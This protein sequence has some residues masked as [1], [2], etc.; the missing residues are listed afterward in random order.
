MI[1]SRG[2]LFFVADLGSA[3]LSTPDRHHAERVLRL[4]VGEEVTLGDGRGG[5]RRAVWTG[6]G[7]EPSGAV[8]TEGRPDPV[9]TV[10]FALVKGSK[11][12]LVVQKLTELSIDRIV[13]FA[14]ERSVVRW[15]D[16][17]V[18]RAHERWVATAREA[19]MQSRRAWLPEIA[20]VT[21][22]DAASTSAVRA[23]RDGRALVAGDITVL[24][25]PEGGWSE[26]EVAAVPE[27]VSLESGVLRAETAA[28][29]AG[30]L[31]S[32]FRE[33]RVHGG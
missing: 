31:M 18:D 28:L 8:Q 27:A 15:D 1:P 10:G 6:N 11:P 2:H 30:L 29:A 21:S 19:S 4:R 32:A 20:P 33:G 5:W 9:L 22:F 14:A 7:L 3:E 12:E 25:G 13:P 17:K 23:D 26:D 24:V 16:H